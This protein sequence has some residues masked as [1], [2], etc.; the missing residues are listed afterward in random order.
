MGCALQYGW[1]VQF[2][3]V[4]KN[5]PWSYAEELLRYLVQLLCILQ[6]HWIAF[7]TWG[8]KWLITV[9]ISSSLLGALTHSFALKLN[10][11]ANHAQFLCVCPCTD[12][13]SRTPSDTQALVPASA[14][15]EDV[16]FSQYLETGLYYFKTVVICSIT[17]ELLH[18][19]V[20]AEYAPTSPLPNSMKSAIPNL[21]IRRDWERQVPS[22]FWYGHVRLH[23]WIFAC[24]FS[25][26]WNTSFS[27]FVTV[28]V[29]LWRGKQVCF[30][31]DQIPCA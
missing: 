28:W 13:P 18:D 31:P 14:T 15:G 9:Q 17:H 29:A 4:T 12:F 7:F 20:F 5:R 22:V 23:S 2:V 25:W 6:L 8:R 10:M 21:V 11:K 3:I 24:A 19:N 26:L 30:T 1:K 16:S 27:V